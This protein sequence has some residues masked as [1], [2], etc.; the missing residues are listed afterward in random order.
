[1]S[2]II[3]E[4]NMENSNINPLFENLSP[5][6][7]DFFDSRLYYTIGLFFLISFVTGLYLYNPGEIMTTYGGPMIFIILFIK[8]TNIYVLVMFPFLIFSRIIIFTGCFMT[9]IQF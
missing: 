1:M 8:K 4:F 6:I 7:K 3:I 9:F 5:L 2:H